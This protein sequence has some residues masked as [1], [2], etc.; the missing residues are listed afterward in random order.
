MRTIII[1]GALING[2]AILIGG[3][4]GLLLKGRIADKYSQSLLRVLGLCVC[5]IGISSAI[6]GDIM[7]LVVSLAFGTFV[8]ELLRI[9]DGLNKLGIWVQGKLKQDG[10]GSTFAQ[11]FVT[12][13]LLFCVGAMAIVGSIDSGLRDDQSIIITKSIID[14]VA[15][16]MF[17]SSL[18]FGVLFSAVAV[19]FY[20]GSIELFAGFFQEVF[21]DSLITQVSAAGGVMILGLGVNMA[22]DMKNKIK[23][24]NLLPG[25]VFAVAYYYVFLT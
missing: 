21:T 17:A 6:G 23:I 20:Q 25:L 11:G 4:I 12:A 1:T 19:F 9:E 24:A 13:S 8:G 5:I 2:A 14:A 18:G 7:L 16:M 15:A 22:L 10:E 3:G